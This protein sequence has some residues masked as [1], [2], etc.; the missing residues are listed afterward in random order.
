[1]GAGVSRGNILGARGLGHRGDSG[2]AERARCRRD[3]LAR[4]VARPPA[5][6]VAEAISRHMTEAGQNTRRRAPASTEAGPTRSDST[7][8]DRR[9]EETAHRRRARRRMPAVPPA[10][11]ALDAGQRQPGPSL[12]PQTGGAVSTIPLPAGSEFNRPPPEEAPVLPATDETPSDRGPR[13]RRRPDV[14]DAPGG[15]RPPPRRSRDIATT[16]PGARTARRGGCSPCPK[17][18]EETRRPCPRPSRPARLSAD[19]TRCSS[20]IRRPKASRRPR[21]RCAP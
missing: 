1:M 14:P 20:H 10:L 18:G 19:R 11:A 7:G 15:W 16:T 3:A 2:V 5:E 21:R 9:P 4:R 13:P 6:M 17:S 8:G 12:D